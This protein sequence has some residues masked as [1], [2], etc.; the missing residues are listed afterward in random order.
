MNPSFTLF[1]AL[2]IASLFA[3]RETAEDTATPAT[4]PEKSS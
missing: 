2:D 1:A 3:R 4:K